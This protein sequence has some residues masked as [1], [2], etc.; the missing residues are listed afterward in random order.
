MYLTWRQRL[1]QCPEYMDFACWPA[2]PIP[3]NLA[4]RKALWRNQKIILAV[5]QGDL[6][7]HV[8]QQFRLSKGRITQLLNRCLAGDSE[9]PPALSQGLIP[10]KRCET[11]QRKA[12]LPDARHKGGATCAFTALLGEHPTLKADLDRFIL[13]RLK[14][15]PYAQVISPYAFFG[16]F[17]RSLA[18]ANWPQ[19]R[20]PYTTVSL[21]CESVR[22]YL[23]RRT[24]ELELDRLPKKT[25]M[26]RPSTTTQQGLLARVQLDEHSVDLHTSMHL[27]L[28]DRW[29]PLRLARAS[30]LVATEVETRAILGYYL[31]PTTH[32][33]QEAL[34]TLLDRCLRPF[35]PK[36]LSLPCLQYVP[37]SQIAGGQFAGV[38]ISFATVQLDNALIHSA[39]S[40]RKFLC[41][42]MGAT[43]HYGFPGMP[44]VRQ[45]VE[46]TFAMVT[47]T[48]SKRFASTTGAHPTDPMRESLKNQKKPPLLTFQMFDEALSVTFANYNATPSATLGGSSPLELLSYLADTQMTPYVDPLTRQQW[49]P[50]LQTFRL[51]I[52]WYRHQHRAPHI[53]F[54]YARYQGD[55]L[56][57]A[58]R[59]H[60]THITV[61][62]NRRDARYLEAISDAG[63]SLGRLTIENP[64]R[65]FAHSVFTRQHIHRTTKALR[66][67]RE[68]PLSGLMHQLLA[69][70]ELPK[71]ASHLLRVYQEFTEDFQEP[72]ILAR[73]HS[74]RE[75]TEDHGVVSWSWS[76]QR[77]THA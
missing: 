19:T 28:D 46:S 16:E 37:G 12:P 27:L 58:L 66:L 74:D 62:L 52:L 7:I 15:Q 64:W 33:N 57:A 39:L 51:R 40:V 17:K 2:L 56:A 48:T 72:L 63:E 69:H 41:D 73:L 54:N 44:Q 9:E 50:L 4:E 31:T 38:P 25:T 67:P 14:D 61:R 11:P 55:A 65:R 42:T 47:R 8:A 3:D 1:Q 70:R 34:L 24:A 13:A 6:L 30:V 32:P 29:I 71:V 43:L 21:A 10:H 35:T 76:T 75:Q 26:L 36:P 18:A 22:T 23:K 77:A 20:Y 45:L 60:Q 59:R 5:L 53:N 68:D 49:T